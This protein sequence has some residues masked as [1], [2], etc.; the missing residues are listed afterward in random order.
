MTQ[1]PPAP[2]QDGS[3]TQS[4]LPGQLAAFI[5]MRA[6][7]RSHAD[8]SIQQELVPA[9]SSDSFAG[10]LSRYHSRMLEE[11]S[12]TPGVYSP[13]YSCSPLRSRNQWQPSP[14]SPLGDNG[15]L[16]TNLAPTQGATG[17][18]Q[19]TPPEALDHGA[20]ESSLVPV[21]VSSLLPSYPTPQGAEG[22]TDGP[23]EA[24]EDVPTRGFIV[25][26]VDAETP[27]RYILDVLCIKEYRS[28]ELICLKYIKDNQKFALA[29]ADVREAINARKVF[30]DSHPEWRIASATAQEIA[31]ITG[32]VEFIKESPQGV[33]LLTVHVPLQRLRDPN[34]EDFIKGLTLNFGQVEQFV[35]FR[36]EVSPEGSSSL[37][38]PPYVGQQS[39]VTPHQG[40]SG[41]FGSSSNMGLGK[42]DCNERIT[43][44]ARIRDG[45][46]VRTTIII[47]HIPKFLDC[48]QVMEALN[49]IKWRSGTNFG[50]AFVNFGDRLDIIT[51]YLALE[52]K[53]W[54]DCQTAEDPVRISYAMVQGKDNLVNRFRNSNVMTRPREERPKL[55]FTSGPFAGLE[56]PFPLPNDAGRLHPHLSNRVNRYPAGGSLPHD[57]PLSSPSARTERDPRHSRGQSLQQNF[58]SGASSTRQ[59]NQTMREL[60]WRRAPQNLPLNS[61]WAPTE[62]DP[63]HSRGQSLQ[64]NFPSGSSFTR[65]GNQNMR[66]L[67]WRTQPTPQ[68]NP[69]N[70][71]LALHGNQTMRPSVRQCLPQNSPLASSLA[72]TERG[73]RH[74]RG[75]SV[76]QNV[77]PASPSAAFEAQSVH[78]SWGP[79]SRS[80]GQQYRAQQPSAEKAFPFTR[81]SK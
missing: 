46:D 65:Q 5:Q 21:F 62:R 42:V 36:F 77:A 45:Q 28:L 12:P 9:A 56:A 10:W 34:N 44:L 24:S 20:Y 1:Q 39:P 73:L 16:Q 78:R 74:S 26:L 2:S 49:R 17:N 33:F 79:Q 47:R 40:N 37:P 48:D 67:E 61:L 23:Q 50:Y 3:S 55:F 14:F 38:L 80:W 63:G 41:G 72:R 43:S 4:S 54:P 15:R 19:H 58:P 31:G 81:E 70:T 8:A 59:G 52:G 68:D 69:E 6:S 35:D 13:D 51:L 60:E 27:H 64:Q 29:F 30:K 11:A 66:Q 25:S 53:K 71:S 57:I 75:Q 76:F 18:I 7:Q 22:L 32:V